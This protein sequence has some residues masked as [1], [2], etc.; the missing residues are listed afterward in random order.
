MKTLKSGVFT[1]L[2]LLILAGTPI[3][4]INAAESGCQ[5]TII[6]VKFHADWCGA[7]KA[8]GAVF[9]DLRN[10]L[11]DK[12][13]LFVELDFTN[14]T[15]RHQAMLMASAL[16]INPA[17]EENPGTGFI[18]LLDG[19]RQVTGKLTSPQTLKQMAAEICVHC[20]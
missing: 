17:L 5:P 13:V 8:M 2:G 9:T 6:A 20:R 12:P 16:G 1:L 10:K 11:D 18:L 3:H 7:C 15:T 4:S 19:K 14:A